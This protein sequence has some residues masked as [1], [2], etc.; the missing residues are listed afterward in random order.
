VVP[1]ALLKLIGDR[2]PKKVAR[3]MHAMMKMVKL[4]L[5]TILRAARGA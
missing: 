1:E 4:D 2:D 5:P 3:V